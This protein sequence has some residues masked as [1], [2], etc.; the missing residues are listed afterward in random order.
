MAGRCASAAWQRKTL[1]PCPGQQVHGVDASRLTDALDAADSLL[2]AKRRPW[3][4]EVDH[5][6]AAMLKVEPLAGGIGGEEQPRGAVGEGA[7][8]SRRSAAVSPPCSVDRSQFLAAA[9]PVCTSVSRYSVNTIAGSLR[10]V[11]KARQC[12][13]LRFGQIVHVARGAACARATGAPRRD[14]RG[15]AP[16]ARRQVPRRPTRRKGEASSGHAR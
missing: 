4:L 2:E 10:P 6:A 13:E 9:T 12:A 16:K 14:R 1:R 5:K 7:K 15:P 11:E 3:Q 8:V